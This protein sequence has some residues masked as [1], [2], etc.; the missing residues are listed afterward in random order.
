LDRDESAADGT[1]GP[2]SY[3]GALGVSL[4]PGAAADADRPARVYKSLPALWET[5]VAYAIDKQ[6]TFD[7]VG[8]SAEDQFDVGSHDA[9]R[10]VH[11]ARSA[12]GTIKL[13]TWEVTLSHVAAGSLRLVSWRLHRTLVLAPI[14]SAPIGIG[15]K[16]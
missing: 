14:G 11:V 6:K 8:G 10:S 1:A 4:F 12:S 16:P 5:D 7:L 3:H 13:D 9:S 2:Q 15:T